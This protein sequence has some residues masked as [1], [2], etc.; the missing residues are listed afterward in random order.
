MFVGLFLFFYEMHVLDNWK[1]ERTREE[2]LEEVKRER[3]EQK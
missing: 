1:Q 2:F 3:Y